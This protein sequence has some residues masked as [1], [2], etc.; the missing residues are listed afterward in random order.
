MLSNPMQSVNNYRSEIERAARSLIE[1]N[2]FEED[3]SIMIRYKDI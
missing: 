2:D 1:K 3:G